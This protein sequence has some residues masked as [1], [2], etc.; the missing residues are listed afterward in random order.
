ME[1]LKSDIWQ[2]ITMLDYAELLIGFILS[3]SLSIV[4]GIAAGGLGSY[5]GFL[6]A[7]LIVGY[8]LRGDITR[9]TLYG[10][11]SAISAGTVFAL[12]MLF[13]ALFAGSEIGLSMM[14]MGFLIMIV[15]IMVDG[16]IGALGG[17]LGSIL[18]Y[19]ITFISP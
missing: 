1:R 14:E 3:I 7:S 17:A 4:L 11:L 18:W 16:M 13:M 15:G 8:R 6:L 10:A 9:G 19:R 5:L 2:V 12:S